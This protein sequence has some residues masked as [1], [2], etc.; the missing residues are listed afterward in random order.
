VGQLEK[1]ELEAVKLFA[2]Q[3]FGFFGHLQGL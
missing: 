3:K 2:Q 1:P